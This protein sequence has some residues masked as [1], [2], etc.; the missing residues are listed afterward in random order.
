MEDD[1]KENRRSY[2]ILSFYQ[3]T[4]PLMRAGSHQVIFRGS[5][6]QIIRN[7]SSFCV[8][9]L[10]RPSVCLCCLLC[11][12]AHLMRISA[13]IS[14]QNQQ[15]N[16]FRFPA[17]VHTTNTEPPA[18]VVS[19]WAHLRCLHLISTSHTQYFHSWLDAEDSCVLCRKCG[20]CLSRH[21][22]RV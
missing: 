12:S 14:A 3:Q 21:K 4:S 8:L 11:V 16:K 15:Q 17:G 20:G 10:L 22:A 9:I 5:I 2:A 6:N 13:Q 18:P 7:N 1:K 19:S